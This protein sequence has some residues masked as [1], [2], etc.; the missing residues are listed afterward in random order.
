[1]IAVVGTG[2]L[3]GFLTR[4]GEWYEGLVKSAFNPPPRVFG[5]VW[6]VLYIMIAVAGSRIWRA[7]PEALQ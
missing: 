3:I 5:P 4:P 1:M 7:S 6:T 2:L